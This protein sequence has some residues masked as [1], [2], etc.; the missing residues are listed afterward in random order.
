MLLDSARKSQT[1][2][3]K[4]LLITIVCILFQFSESLFKKSF[5]TDFKT[6]QLLSDKCFYTKNVEVCNR[7]LEKAEEIQLV[8]GVENNYSCQTKLL[9]FQAK[10]IMIFMDMSKGFTYQDNLDDIKRNCKLIF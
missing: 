1:K 3:L 7:A 8:A 10:L 4:L 9:G 6:L 5:A 2:A